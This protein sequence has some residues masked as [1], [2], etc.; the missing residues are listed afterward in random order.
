MGVADCCV[1]PG[2]SHPVR[3]YQYCQTFLFEMDE[4]PVISHIQPLN[5]AKTLPNLGNEWK[6]LNVEVVS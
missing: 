1:A 3:P 4:R 6:H 2:E 5:E